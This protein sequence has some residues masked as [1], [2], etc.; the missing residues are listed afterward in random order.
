MA[1]DTRTCVGCAACVIAC[2]TENRIS[3]G[4]VR[5]WITTET[6]GR[7]PELMMTIRSERCN[8]CRNA[9]CVRACPTGASHYAEGGTVQVTGSKCTGCKACMAA[10]PYDA[11]YVDE[12]SGTVDKCTFCNHRTSRGI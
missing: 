3:E 7:F 9:A 4:Y 2:K 1:V 8:H 5:N 10:C 11:R 12:Q 6:R